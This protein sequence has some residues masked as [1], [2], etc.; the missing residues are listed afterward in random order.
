[1]GKV[2]TVSASMALFAGGAW[3]K[4]WEHKVA[5]LIEFCRA[6]GDSEKQ[7]QSVFDLP[8]VEGVTMAFDSILGCAGVCK[9]LEL[10][11]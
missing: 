8:L 3:L 1:M 5:G 4:N 11:S 2:A 9:D 10:S 6:N 7:K